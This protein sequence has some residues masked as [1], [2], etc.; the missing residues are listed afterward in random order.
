MQ[1]QGPN[2]IITNMEITLD[3]IRKY[4][5]DRTKHTLQ[6]DDAKYLLERALEL[7]LD[8]NNGGVD[9]LFSSLK[10]KFE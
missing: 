9:A 10:Y 3:E 1:E 5:F 7:G 8:R 2:P 4:Y 6:V